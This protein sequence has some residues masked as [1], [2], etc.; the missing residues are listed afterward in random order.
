[1]G[2]YALPVGG[3]MTAA[4]FTKTSSLDSLARNASTDG[5]MVVRSARSRYR[6]ARRPFD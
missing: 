2:R 5:L 1:M 3:T 4:L 6:N